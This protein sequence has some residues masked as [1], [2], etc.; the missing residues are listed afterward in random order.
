MSFSRVSALLLAALFGLVSPASANPL[1]SIDEDDR[2]ALE[3]VALYPEDVREHALQV[4]SEPALLIDLQ[5]LQERSQDDFRDLLGPYSQDDQ[6]QLFELSR[7]PDLVEAIARGGEKSRAELER[8]AA[9]YPEDVRAAALRQGSEHHKVVSRMHALLADFDGR[10]GDL[11]E[12]LPPARQQAFRG[13]L[14][15]PELLSLLTEHTAMTVLLGDAFEREPGAVRD[16]LADLNLQVAKRNAEDA[17]DWKRSVDSDP[18]LRRDYDAAAQDYHNDTGYS[19]YQAPSQTVVN[20]SIN[21]YPFWVGYPWWYPVAYDYYDPWYWWYPRSSWGH[22]GYSYGP[23]VV[24]YGGPF[25][26][27]WYPSYHFTSWYFSHGD[28]HSHYPYLSDRF[29]SYY[30]RPVVVNN[31]HHYNVQ[32]R[33]VNKFVY[34]TNTVMPANYLRGKARKDRIERFR[35]YG[36]IAP[37]IEKVERETRHKDLVAKRGKRPGRDFDF[38]EDDAAGAVARAE[39]RKLVA[40][41]PKEFPE[42]SKVSKEDWERPRGK[43]RGQEAAGGLEAG[44]DSGKGKAKG[45]A[46]LPSLGDD[47]GGK[48]KGQGGGKAHGTATSPGDEAGTGTGKGKGGGTES[49]PGDGERGKG[50]ARELEATDESPRSGK[51]HKDRTATPKAT[52]TFQPPGDEPTG[53]SG[54]GKSRGVDRSG[55]GGGKSKGGNSTGGGGKSKETSA[56]PSFTAPDRGNERDTAR[57]PEPK[58][59]KESAAPKYQEPRNDAP[60]YQAPKYEAPKYQAPPQVERSGG[61]HGSGGGGG[62]GNDGGAKAKKKKDQGQDDETQDSGGRGKGNR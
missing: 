41:N 31:Y 22:C 6:E 46:A 33:V 32:R 54:G 9:D 57:D 38:R 56:Q 35:E 49:S 14:R 47:T 55:D 62:G 37:E 34:R 28:H 39:A 44:R 20:V 30:D 29:V 15:T 3:A 27:P 42:L 13:M 21:P 23:R 52:P 51:G 19:A 24:L 26:A 18:D 25:W 8:I 48:G 5:K 43:G 7:Y 40:K 53:G 61:G 60:K 2:E 11:I 16:A 12:D 17:K 1:D 45:S 59:H 4:A 50:K 36:K 58:R 10:F